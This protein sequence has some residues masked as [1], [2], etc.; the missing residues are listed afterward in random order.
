M[1]KK[2]G[3]LIGILTAATVIQLLV[4]AYVVGVETGVNSQQYTIKTLKEQLTGLIIDYGPYIHPLRNTL[5]ISSLI[6]AFCWILVAVVAL[7]RNRK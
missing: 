1:G 6:I 3:T 5:F 4:V 2:F 7:Q